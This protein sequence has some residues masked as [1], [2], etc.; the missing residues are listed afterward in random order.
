MVRDEQ[1]R[2]TSST[3]LLLHDVRR[4]STLHVACIDRQSPEREGYVKARCARRALRVQ[5]SQHVLPSS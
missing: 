4:A 2:T 5:W 1:S 3:T